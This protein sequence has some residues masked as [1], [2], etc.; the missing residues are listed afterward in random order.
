MGYSKRHRAALMIKWPKVSV[1][2]DP[3][4]KAAMGSF[5]KPVSGSVT[6]AIIKCKE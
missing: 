4:V 5:K 3:L 2:F 1:L 6:Q